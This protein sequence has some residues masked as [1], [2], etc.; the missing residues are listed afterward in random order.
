MKR[1]IYIKLNVMI[2]L[3]W[4]AVVAFIAKPL[5]HVSSITLFGGEQSS[6]SNRP[7]THHAI[8]QKEAQEKQL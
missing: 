4:G 6:R 5:D 3:F 8:L 7:T 1:R 2:Y